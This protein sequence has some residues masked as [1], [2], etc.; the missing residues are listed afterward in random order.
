MRGRV[1]VTGASGFVGGHV[2]RAL[3]AAFPHATLLGAT[4]G[5]A[6]P[7]WDAAVPLD[8]DDPA[9][10]EAAVRQARPDAVMHLAARA[11]VRA[12]FDDPA[13]TWRSNLGGT[14]AL[15]G[16]VLRE[17]PEAPFLFAS[18]AEVHGLAF[19]AGRLDEDAAMRPANPYA[20]TKAAADLALG[21]MA[22]RG[23]R[24]VR[25]RPVTHCG[26][27]QGTGFV[28]ADFA[29]QAARIAAG[30]QAPLMRVGALDRWRDML[31]VRDVARGYALALERAEALEPG[32]A[33]MLASGVPR[34]IGD[35]LDG[36]LARFGVSP[37]IEVAAALLR[38]TDLERT[39]G[40][41]SRAAALL[42]WRAEIGWEATLDAVAA[43]WRARVAAGG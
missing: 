7:G 8:L 38:P 9:S 26:P 21:E 29:R 41:A 17:A 42:G 10:V 35:V 36:L 39:E 32:V 2:L 15:A 27:G 24:A 31:D 22:L 34:R 37:R 4:R 33:I 11:G 43:D 12:A 16:A 30:L 18:S 28:V 1:L 6:L 3:R 23:L 13:A 40:D 25:L 14:L 5:E 20:A 19:R